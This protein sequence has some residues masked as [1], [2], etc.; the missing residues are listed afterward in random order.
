MTQA[1]I[2]GVAHTH[3]GELPELT[4]I[5]INIAAATAAVADAGLTMQD[6]DGLL[7]QPPFWA[8]PRY[9]MLIGESSTSCSVSGVRI[10]AAGFSIA[11]LR[12]VTATGAIAS[13]PR[14]YSCR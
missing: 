6:I 13:S 14:P 8:S 5:G 10:V 2:S 3:L 12:V 4:D 9:H 11:C 1:V 7:V